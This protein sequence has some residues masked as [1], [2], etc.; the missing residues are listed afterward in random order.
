[1]QVIFMG[2]DQFAIPSLK[3][4]LDNNYQVQAVVTSPDKPQGRGLKLLPMPV[5]AFGQERK[6]LLWSPSDLKSDDF[7]K[8]LQETKPDV[9][10]VVAFNILPEEVFSVPPLGTVNL[11]P[12]L[13]PKYRGAAPM[14]WAIINGDEETGVTTFLI[15]KKIDAGQIIMQR[16]VKILPEESY[17]EL[18]ERLSKIGAEVLLESLKLIQQSNFKPLPQADSISSKAPKIKKED[19]RINWSKSAQNIKNLVR[20][21]SPEP[22]AFTTYKDKM[23]KIFKTEILDDKSYD[24]GFGEVVSASDKAGLVVKTGQG[25]LKLASLQLEGKKIIS[26]EEFVRGYK[27]KTGEKFI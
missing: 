15:E 24:N 13:L 17:G 19:C 23:V 22:G 21:L 3:A 14:Q 25:S 6:L 8:Q 2:N 12:S 11:H 7:L 1:M 4:L 16:R 10:V 18:S 9:I 5:K 20:G 26:G 27:I